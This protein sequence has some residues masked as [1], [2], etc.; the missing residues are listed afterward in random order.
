MFI[1]PLVRNH[2]DQIAKFLA[3]TDAELSKKKRN[4]SGYQIKDTWILDR[5]W[6]NAPTRITI[7]AETQGELTISVTEDDY[8]AFN[9][10]ESSVIST[11]VE[12]THSKGNTETAL[13]F[14]ADEADKKSSGA[15]EQQKR[16]TA[17]LSVQH[18][19]ADESPKL[20]LEK[21]DAT[22]DLSKLKT[23]ADN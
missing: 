3:I 13:L 17:T 5:E 20:D 22:Y 16:M 18:S 8:S 10:F 23:P 14:S 12:Q 11:E 19:P 9:G 7:S 4:E 6:W 2:L 1:T 15:T 21:A